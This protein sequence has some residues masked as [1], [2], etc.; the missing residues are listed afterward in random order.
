MQSTVTGF[1]AERGMRNLNQVHIAPAIGRSLFME[2]RVEL[3]R[4]LNAAEPA[5]H[6]TVVIGQWRQADKLI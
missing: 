5:G 4:R 1:D 3:G 2:F 6:F